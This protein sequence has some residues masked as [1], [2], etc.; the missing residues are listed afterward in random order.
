LKTTRHII[1]QIFRANVN[2]DSQELREYIKLLMDMVMAFVTVP[3][4]QQPP[5]RNTTNA[6]D[7]DGDDDNLVTMKADDIFGDMIADSDDSSVPRV[8]TQKKKP[9]KISFEPPTPTSATTTKQSFKA[10]N[11]FVKPTKTNASSS[12]LSLKKTS[13]AKHKSSKSLTNNKTSSSFKSTKNSSTRTLLNSPKTPNTPVNDKVVE[14]PS[15]LHYPQIQSVTGFAAASVTFIQDEHIE[16]PVELLNRTIYEYCLFCSDGK[17]TSA[18]DKQHI[19]PLCCILKVYASVATVQLV[20][21]IEQTPALL[22]ILMTR[23]ENDDTIAIIINC[24]P[25]LVSSFFDNLLTYHEN[26]FSDIQAISKAYA[27]LFAVLAPTKATKSYESFVKILAKQAYDIHCFPTLCLLSVHYPHVLNNH[28][29]FQETLETVAM[30]VEGVYEH[31]HEAHKLPANYIAEI[32][33][34]NLRFVL[35]EY[36]ITHIIGLLHYII[37]YSTEYTN[38]FKETM[39]R[40]A[41]LTIIVL[42]KSDVYQNVMIKQLWQQV[43]VNLE[44]K[45]EELRQAFET[46]CNKCLT[47]K[48][49]NLYEKFIIMVSE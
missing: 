29:C 22:N 18:K 5:K 26:V 7:D 12:S 32:I 30:E 4:L 34:T 23:P 24:I 37:R 14:I 39:V 11:S 17:Y 46:E 15:I 20:E 6:D 42:L 45:K 48:H 31:N 47:F 41:Y 25:L 9:T 10:S 38:S 1:E 16:L 33:K 21:I 28:T 3:L 13:S 36:K 2:H 49:L 43:L 40:A 19:I 27:S 35:S 44:D 8:V